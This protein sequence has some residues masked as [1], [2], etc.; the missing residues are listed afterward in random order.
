MFLLL[1]PL[2][3]G[4]VNQHLFQPAILVGQRAGIDRLLYHQDDITE[5]LAHRFLLGKAE[6]VVAPLAVHKVMCEDKDD[7]Q[8][9]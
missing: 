9:E 7:L 5:C 8:M 4:L 6:F 2:Q 3:V 1:W